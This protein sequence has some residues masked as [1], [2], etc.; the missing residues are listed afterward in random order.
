[1]R[2]S[3]DRHGILLGVNGAR[4]NAWAS[5]MQR[6]MGEGR[7]VYLLTLGSHGRPPSV[8]TLDAAPLGEVATNAEQEEFYQQWLSERGSA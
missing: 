8:R 4:R 3:L 7:A 2:N 5:G 1:L 6:D